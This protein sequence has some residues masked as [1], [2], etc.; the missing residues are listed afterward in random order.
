MRGPLPLRK[1][2]KKDNRI[3]HH[4]PFM[5]FSYIIEYAMYYPR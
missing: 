2:E 4:H 3:G 5:R 1:E